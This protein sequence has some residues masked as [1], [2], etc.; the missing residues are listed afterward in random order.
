MAMRATIA[1]ILLFVL[2]GAKADNGDVPE[3]DIPRGKGETC[4]ADPAFMRL[5]HMDLLR[6]ERD[7][8]VLEG[9][10]DTKFSLKDC[11]ACHAVNGADGQPVKASSPQHFCSACH[12]YVAVRIDCF[13]C[14]ASRPEPKVADRAPG[15]MSSRVFLESPHSEEKPANETYEDEDA[16]K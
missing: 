13:E 12:N 3:P 4:V 7:E 10:R 1:I 14:H 11:V 5:N 9:I 6:H 2:A 15:T 16:A 8:T